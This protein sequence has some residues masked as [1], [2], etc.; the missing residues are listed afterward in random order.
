MPGRWSKLVH[1]PDYAIGCLLLLT[2][3]SVLAFENLFK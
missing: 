3:G 1:S 2:D